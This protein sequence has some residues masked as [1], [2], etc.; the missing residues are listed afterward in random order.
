M[1]AGLAIADYLLSATRNIDAI[2]QNISH[3]LHR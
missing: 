2:I 1:Q 3:N